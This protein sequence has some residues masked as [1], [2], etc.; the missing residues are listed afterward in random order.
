MQRGLGGFPHERLHQE[1]RFIFVQ[2]LRTGMSKTAIAAAKIYLVKFAIENR[3][4][5]SPGYNP[6]MQVNYKLTIYN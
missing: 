1:V 6:W 2:V 4:T 3:N 5:E